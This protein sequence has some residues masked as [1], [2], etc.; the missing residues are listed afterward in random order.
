MF[1]HKIEGYPE[2]TSYVYQLNFEPIAGKGKLP[3]FLCVKLANA[4]KLSS[5]M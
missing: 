4:G 3:V 1:L 2:N 5:H